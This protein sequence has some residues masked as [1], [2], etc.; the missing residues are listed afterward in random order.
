[1]HIEASCSC[2][3]AY[4]LRPELAGKRV[5]CKDCGGS[6]EVPALSTSED[7]DWSAAL[8]STDVSAD[9]G[10]LSDDALG[11]DGYALQNVPVVP[12]RTCSKCGS[13]LQPEAIL[14][15]NCGFN[16]KTGQQVKTVREVEAG[17]HRL[18]GGPMQTALTVV[19]VFFLL[20]G[21]IVTLV[22]FSEENGAVALAIGIVIGLGGAFVCTCALLL[23]RVV[24]VDLAVNGKTEIVKSAGIGPLKFV[25]HYPAAE[26]DA[27]WFVQTAKKQDSNRGLMLFI[28]LLLFCMGA[29]PGIIWWVILLRG[30]EDTHVG[31][32][33]E[34]R[35]QDQR[36]VVLLSGGEDA[37]HD[38][39]AI[40]RLIRDAA[41]LRLEQDLGL[42]N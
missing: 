38:A 27:V 22:A 29:I 3:R 19:G 16:S 15:L 4:R 17:E 6:F 34:L 26:Y 25:S 33:V 2:G 35:K 14:C 11:L 12:Q 10:A 21:G 42:V 8:S 23:R 1:M 9:A 24:S 7:D 31:Y 37:K 28:M 5:K 36:S 41:G 20:V 32:R 30:D 13:G 39:N 18:S 40:S